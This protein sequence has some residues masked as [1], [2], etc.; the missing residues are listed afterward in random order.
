MEGRSNLSLKHGYL[1]ILPANNRGE[2]M[3]LLYRSVKYDVGM[4]VSESE[5]L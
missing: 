2:G 5:S 4:G 3:S 1:S